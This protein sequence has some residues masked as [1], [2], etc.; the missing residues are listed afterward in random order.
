VYSLDA[1]VLPALNTRFPPVYSFYG[2]YAATSID[3]CI[4]STSPNWP[5]IEDGPCA[6]A[7]W[8]LRCKYQP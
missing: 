7:P 4:R 8:P 5:E 1:V 6:I 2:N 3:L